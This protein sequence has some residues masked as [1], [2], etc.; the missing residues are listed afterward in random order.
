MLVSSQKRVRWLPLIGATAFFV[1]AGEARGGNGTATNVSGLYYT[2]VNNGYGLLNGDTTDSHWAVTYASTNG[3]STADTTYEGAAYVVDAGASNHSAVN[4]VSGSGWIAN[5]G[6]AQ[7]IVPPGATDSAGNNVNTGNTYLPGNGGTWA[8]PYS[9]ASDPPNDTADT[10]EGVYVYTLAF[11]ITGNVGSGASKNNV[12]NF[13]VQMTAAGDDQLSIYV[14]PAGNG[15][16]IPTGTA[17]FVTGDAWDNT[18]VA[19]LN[20]S[21]S[22]FVIGTNYLVVVVDNTN[23]E[24]GNNGSTTSNAS[25]LLIYNMDSFI[26]GTPIPEVGTWL[27]V[28]GAVGL[29]GMALWRRSRRRPSLLV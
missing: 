6:T 22:N 18:T 20:S 29:Y 15:A 3:G 13:S 8:T 2:G 27:P 21:N 17:A 7:W 10:N 23:S 14:N 19:T 24:S 28:V 9:A 5:S 16:S 4:N 25:G 12:T 11:T 26:G 1:L